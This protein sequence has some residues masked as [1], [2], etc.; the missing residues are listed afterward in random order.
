M[1]DMA[2]R[3]LDKIISMAPILSVSVEYIVHPDQFLAGL[4]PLSSLYDLC[5]SAAAI[6]STDGC[7]D[8]KRWAEPVWGC[9]C[10]S[11]NRSASFNPVWK[12]IARFPWRT[13]YYCSY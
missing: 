5:L 11:D 9:V 10:C 7:V 6:L 8:D 12:D 3:Y 1:C 4:I 13:A 2:K